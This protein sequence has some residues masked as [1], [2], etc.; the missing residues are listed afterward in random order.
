MNILTRLT[1]VFAAGALAMPALAASRGGP[2]PE[3]QR[4]HATE[5]GARLT[6]AHSAA[7]AKAAHDEAGAK[8]LQ[9]NYWRT[10]PASCLA[11]PLPENPTGPV[12]SKTVTL[13]ARNT[14][15]LDQLYSEDVTISIW[16]VACSSSGEFYNSATLMRIDRQPQY[17]G[18]NEYYPLFPHV[19]VDQV[20]D[21]ND[22]PFDDPDLRDYVRVAVEPNTVISDVTIDSPIVYSQTYV[23]ENFPGAACNGPCFDFNFPFTIRFD[24]FLGSA[25]DSQYFIE[26]PVYNPTQSTYPDAFASLPINGYM[27]S[28]WYQPGKGGEGIVVQVYERETSNVGSCLDIGGGTILPFS[29]TWFTYDD[30]G[31]PFFLFGDDCVRAAD[32]TRLTVDTYYITGLGFAGDFS[33]D[34][35]TLNPWGQVSFEFPTCN[36]MFVDYQSD[37]GL[38]AGIPAGTGSL[39]YSRI[40]NVNGLTCE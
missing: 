13:A 34:D 27:S 6:L 26:V 4:S 23:L 21:A 37:S 33:Q 14:D 30:L 18:D 25:A 11:D 22:I 35:R 12:Y 3:A 15:D 36:T 39:D 24:N 31:F 8:A 1:F 7:A 32:P 5:Q 19:S 17:E 20:T 2:L 29:F 10:Y 38:P 40:A 28:N 9:A 16:R